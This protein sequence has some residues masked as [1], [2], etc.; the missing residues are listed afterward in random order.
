MA[1]AVTAGVAPLLF[2]Q[3]LFGQFFYT[4]SVL[5]AVFLLLVIPLIIVGYYALY[6]RNRSASSFTPLAAAMTATTTVILLYIAFALSSDVTLMLNPENWKAYAS[7]RSGTILPLAEPS[8]F[9]RYLH[10]VV[11]ALAVGGL[12]MAI[13]VRA[14]GRVGSGSDAERLGLRIFAAATVAEM[15][16]GAWFLFSL[17][18]DFA[19]RFSGGEAYPTLV[20]AAGIAFG[21][22]ALLAAAYGKFAPTLALAPASVLSM[23]LARDALRTMF[24]SPYFDP[25]SLELRPQYDVLALFL[26][27]LAAGA[28]LV[29][30][31]VRVG[32]RTS[33]KEASP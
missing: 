33:G 8:T 17:P 21:L 25:S 2:L 30:Y 32:F 23:V 9:P 31:M 19:R 7:N 22:A 29:A 24:L 28:A 11:G 27:V 15:A 26:L 1:W 5:M 20:L 3:L 12:A 6:V 13:L 18:G 14:R 4:S 16:V 10:F